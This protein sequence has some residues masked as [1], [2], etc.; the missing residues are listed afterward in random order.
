M[1]NLKAGV[2]GAWTKARGE[3]DS[4]LA[5]QEA[6]T[7]MQKRRRD[8]LS[9]HEPPNGNMNS[10]STIESQAIG[11]R[12]STS[13]GNPQPA[14]KKRTLASTTKKLKKQSSLGKIVFRKSS[15]SHIIP[16]PTT[17]GT[18]TPSTRSSIVVPEEIPRPVGAPI[19][20]GGI[21]SMHEEKEDEDGMRKKLQSLEA[22]VNELRAKVQWFEQTHGE[23]PSETL[24]EI[25]HSLNEATIKKQRRS[26]FKEELDI[27]PEPDS[28]HVDESF[29][30]REVKDLK[31]FERD[32]FVSIPEE[33]SFVSPT[34]NNADITLPVETTIKLI[35]PSPSTKSIVSPPR[36]A[37]ASMSPEKV[38][39]SPLSSPDK[40]IDKT[41]N[42][43]ETLSPIH[44][45]IM[46]ALIP[47]K[48][49]SEDVG[50]KLQFA[51]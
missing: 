10:K 23:I 35:Q 32:T 43:L 3:Y 51:I 7:R 8:I 31:G 36:P 33:D 18:V 19:Y 50:R 1:G 39:V 21:T 2:S 24:T 4:Y 20:R 5:T 9:L 42:L 40:D 27:A 11:K 25:Q 49:D 30:P 47:R 37:R 46:P 26:V 16:P 48:S 41:I 15:G 45:N 44:P 12:P 34:I 17:V 28:T 29:L 14:V 6:E 38:T 13:D 22:E